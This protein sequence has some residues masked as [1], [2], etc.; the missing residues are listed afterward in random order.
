MSQFR[1]TNETVIGLLI[2][3]VMSSHATQAYIF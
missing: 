3:C 1:P 2:Y